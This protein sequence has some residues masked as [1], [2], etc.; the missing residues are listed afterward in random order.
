MGKNSILFDVE[1]CPHDSSP[2]ACFS[3]PYIRVFEYGISSVH[4]RQKVWLNT[5]KYGLA[6]CKNIDIFLDPSQK[7][8]RRARIRAFHDK[9]GQK[10]WEKYH[11]SLP[12]KWANVP[13]SNQPTDTICVWS[14]STHITQMCHLAHFILA[15]DPTYLPNTNEGWSKRPNAMM[16]NPSTF[17]DLTS[18]LFFSFLILF[19]LKWKREQKT[20]GVT[21]LLR[22]LLLFFTPRVFFTLSY[23]TKKWVEWGLVLQGIEEGL[24]FACTSQEWENRSK[25]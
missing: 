14:T 3:L 25:L 6:H 22:E 10:M 1:F 15:P 16:S 12:E 20:E 13:Y 24:K 21:W 11:Y 9:N 7:R 19:G 5:S 4:A 18:N 8:E 17:E 23:N 2:P